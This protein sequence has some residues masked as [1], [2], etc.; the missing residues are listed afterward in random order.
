MKP[1]IAL[2]L[3]KIV[4]TI[5][6]AY[7]LA[8]PFLNPSAGG[9]V[10]KELEMLGVVGST[11]LALAFLTLI[12]L[13]GRDLSRTLSLVRPSARTASPRSVWLMFLIPYNFV[14][15]FFIVYNVA[16]SLRQEAQHNAALHSFKSFGMVSGQGWCAAQI[17][18]LLPN[19]IGSIAGVLALP[20]WIV[21]WR[22]VR[23]V[24]AVLAEAARS[25]AQASG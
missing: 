24:N 1:S 11:L 3:V 15:D 4:L 25:K 14:E 12:F 13:Y 5:P 10:F 21:H 23:Q 9:G 2:I 19:E 8:Y 20:L 16:S 22:L 7:A 17:V 18:S 6:V